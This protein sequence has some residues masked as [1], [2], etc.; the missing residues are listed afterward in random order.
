MFFFYSL[1]HSL[2][3]KS[4]PC[5]FD[6]LLLHANITLNSYDYFK[7]F[8]NDHNKLYGLFFATFYFIAP[9]ALRNL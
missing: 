8:M 7:M 6:S 9:F 3:A 5:H 1:R 4:S 2:P